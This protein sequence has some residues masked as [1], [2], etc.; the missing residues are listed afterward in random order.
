MPSLVVIQLFVVVFKGAI[1]LVDKPCL[2]IVDSS[3]VILTWKSFYWS[4]TTLHIF[5]CAKLPLVS[6][7]VVLYYLGKAKNVM[8][9]SEHTIHIDWSIKILFT[10]FS[11][12]YDNFR[13]PWLLVSNSGASNML[14][15]WSAWKNIRIVFKMLQFMCTA[16][17]LLN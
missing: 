8:C 12:Y 10:N 17:K 15:I 6:C 13:V 1:L 2:F 5:S 7:F 14:K 11:Q 9:L 4:V 16:Q 3:C